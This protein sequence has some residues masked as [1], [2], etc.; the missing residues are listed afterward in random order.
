MCHKYP[1]YFQDFMKKKYPLV[2]LGMFSNT[3]KHQHSTSSKRTMMVL[4]SSPWAKG[5]Q[6][7]TRMQMQMSDSSILMVNKNP[8]SLFLE[9]N[10]LK[11]FLKYLG[12]SAILVNRQEPFTVNKI[13][14][15]SQPKQQCLRSKAHFKS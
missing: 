8:V 13:S 14:Y 6:M 15:P 9:K 7:T 5:F 10:I 12:K 3:G 2:R 4:Y 11:G 1:H